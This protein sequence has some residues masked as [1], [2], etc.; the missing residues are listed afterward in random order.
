[1]ISPFITKHQSEFGLAL[2][3]GQLEQADRFYSLVKEAN[4]HLHLTGPCDEEE[5]AIRHFLESANLSVRYFK[6]RKF[7]DVGS[8]GGFPGIPLLIVY[9][10]TTARLIESKEKKARFLKNVVKQLGLA[11]RCEVV[12]K[13]F[14][15]TDCR[16]FDHVFTRALDKLPSKIPDLIK[17]AHR[18]TL[19]LMAGPK[20]KDV[21]NQNQ[22]RFKE[23]LIP[24]SEQ[25]YSFEI[26]KTP[27]KERRKRPNSRN[28]KRRR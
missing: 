22:I 11:G 15:E 25:R 1:M 17:W 18:S 28:R 4:E 20:V 3:D 24:L 9:P 16:G 5:F 10:T 13:Q 2:S 14:A 8:G 19:V 12:N 6:V 26:K 23:T 7:V 27:K 21:L